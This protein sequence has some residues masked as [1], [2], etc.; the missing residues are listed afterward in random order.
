MTRTALGTA[1]ER[2]GPLPPLPAGLDDPDT[3]IVHGL[4]AGRTDSDPLSVGPRHGRAR[5][6]RYLAA[7]DGDTAVGAAVVDLGVVGVAFAWAQFGARTYTWERRVPLRRGLAVGRGLDSAA[8]VRLTGARLQLDADGGFRV[9]VPVGDGRRVTA[10]VRCAVDVTPAVAITRTPE[11]G[12]NATQKAAGY[13]ATGWVRLGDETRMPLGTA[14]SGWRDA[15]AGRQDR[16]TTWRWAAGG[17]RGEGGRRVGLNAG[18]GM[19]EAGEGECVVWWDGVPH[20][21]LVER[22]GPEDEWDPTG[23]WV[24]AGPGWT[25]WFEP[26]GVRAKDE[27]LGVLTSRYVQPIG[28]FRGTLPGPDGQPVDVELVGVTEDHLAVW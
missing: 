17:G 20:R 8:A 10:D 28:W 21:L 27:R 19:N 15:T 6:W 16:T 1:D 5:R 3:G 14:A 12:W 7:S 18:T 22:L 23:D 26:R 24:V 9:D 2:H 13:L 4:F 11:G 25:L